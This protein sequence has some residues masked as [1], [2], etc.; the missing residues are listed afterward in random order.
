M[1]ELI[2]LFLVGDDLLQDL[3]L[4][5]EGR[6]LL[7]QLSFLVA[8]GPQQVVLALLG[9]K[10]RAGRLIGGRHVPQLQEIKA[11]SQSHRSAHD[12]GHLRPARQFTELRHM[13]DRPGYDFCGCADFSQTRVKT[14]ACMVR[15]VSSW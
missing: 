1:H 13:C 11:D 5:L 6:N 4:L 2:G 9:L 8:V 10:R 12:H 7:L 3:E 15:T 14:K